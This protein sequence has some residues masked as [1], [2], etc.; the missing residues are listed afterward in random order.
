MEQIPTLIACLAREALV[1]EQFLDLLH[2]Q[3]RCL[4]ASDLAGLT[5]CTERQREK[6]VE[7]QLLHRQREDLLTKMRQDQ[8]W[9]GDL[10]LQRLIDLASVDQAEQMRRIRETI[11]GLHEQIATARDA[12]MLL[13]DRSR[14]VIAKTLAMLAAVNNGPAAYNGDQHRPLDSQRLLMDR[15]G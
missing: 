11:F 9:R 5:S 10:N 1:F 3:R 7:A 15:R 2:D 6:L 4:V 12:N 14:E 8:Q 13:I